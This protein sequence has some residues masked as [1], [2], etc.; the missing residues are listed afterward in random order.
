MLEDGQKRS[1]K[2]KQM[3]Q[4]LIDKIKAGTLDEI[5]KEMIA[6]RV[7]NAT[8]KIMTECANSIERINALLEEYSVEVEMAGI[9]C[10]LL[11][12]CKLFH[13]NDGESDCCL[14]VGSS[15]NLSAILDH[16][17]SGLKR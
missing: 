10:V 17:K 3:E 11:S 6:A 9:S 4:I 12:Q 16:A 1:T 8:D 13:R 15:R 2:D 5:D 7:K 14:V